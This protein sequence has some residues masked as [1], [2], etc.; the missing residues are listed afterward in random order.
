M[1][2][3][4]KEKP[5]PEQT[6]EK[7]KENLAAMDIGIVMDLTFDRFIDLAIQNGGSLIIEWAT[8]RGGKN[9]H[10]KAEFTYEEITA[11]A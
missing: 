7:I 1:G 8:D 4:Q 6:L 11:K 2:N 5:T 3:Q 10:C 9:Y